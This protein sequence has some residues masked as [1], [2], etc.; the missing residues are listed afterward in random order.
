MN[1]LQ[2]VPDYAVTL[3]N[4]LLLI[5]WLVAV[6]GARKKW[7]AALTILGAFVVGCLVGSLIGMLLVH[8]ADAL[9]PVFGWVGGF[10]QALFEI[11]HNLRAKRVQRERDAN[12]P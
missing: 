10:V 1:A 8:S 12:R 11:N 6:V 2:P 4:V 5:L 7:R 9:A 3:A